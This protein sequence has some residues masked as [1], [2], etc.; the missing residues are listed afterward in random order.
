M[1]R[2][3]K[4]RANGNGRRYL[5]K[6]G[7]GHYFAVSENDPCSGVYSYSG[8]RVTALQDNSDFCPCHLT[9]LEGTI[10]T[11]DYGRGSISSFPVVDGIVQ[12]KS[13]CQDLVP[14]YDFKQDILSFGDTGEV[15]EPKTLRA[16]IKEIINQL[17]TYYH[18]EQ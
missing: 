12:P 14:D 7:K 10:Y 2:K 16:S 8:S 3:Q 13:G 1:Y 9:L 4:F 17:N 15:L 11:A 5:I 18:G 6:D